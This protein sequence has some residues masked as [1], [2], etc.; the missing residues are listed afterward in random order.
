M[1][2][3]QK[4]KRGP[5]ERSFS[6]DHGDGR[7]AAPY[8][9]QNQ[10]IVQ[11]NQ[12]HYDHP[13]G[14]GRGGRGGYGGRGGAANNT[15]VPTSP[16]TV[17][18]SPTTEVATST[19]PPPSRTEPPKKPPPSPSV[20]KK[21]TAPAALP[22][23][24]PDPK[25]ITYHF[26]HL[27]DEVVSTWKT[28]G[29]QS[30]I[31]AAVKLQEDA[32]DTDPI[33]PVFQELIKSAIWRRLTPVEAGDAIKEIIAVAPK[34][35]ELDLPECFLDILCVINPD[36]SYPVRKANQPAPADSELD[37]RHFVFRQLLPATAISPQLMREILDPAI[38][39]GANMVRP[40]FTSKAIRYNTDLNYR[41]PSFNLLRED[42]EGF[43][44]LMTEYFTAASKS[45]LGLLKEQTDD[46]WEKI[47]ALVGAFDM[48]I[49]RV[50]DVTLTVFGSVLIRHSRFFVKLLRAS[51]WWPMKSLVDGFDFE[52][53]LSGLP[54]WA[55]PSSAVGYY[56]DEEKEELA[57]LRTSRDVAF[58]DRVRE[59]GI[60][61]YFALGGRRVKRQDSL[62]NGDG[63]EATTSLSDPDNSDLAWI[64]ATGTVRPNGSRLAAQVLGFNFQFYYGQAREKND[65]IPD[66]LV[67]L[68]AL[69]IKIGFISFL[70]FYPYVYP[71]DE[72]MD[73]VREKLQKEKELRDKGRRPNAGENALMRAGALPDDAPSTAPPPRIREPDT[74]GTA[75]KA[76]SSAAEKSVNDGKPATEEA[77]ALPEPGDQK[78]AL[79]KHLLALGA[80]PESVFILSKFP[81][82]V[83]LVPELPSYI[84][85]IVDY[86][87]SKIAQAS[88]Q[89]PDPRSVVGAKP[90]IAEQLTKELK[91]VDEA[92][93][94][95]LR[96]Q[97][98]DAKWHMNGA[99]YKFYWED[100]A[101]Q[102][103]QCQTVD[104]FFS[105]CGT[106]ANIL[107]FKIGHDPELYVKF[108]R[109][110]KYS[111]ATDRSDANVARWKD[112]CK[113]LLLPASTLLD[114]SPGMFTRPM[115]TLHSANR[116]NR[117]CI[118]TV[119][120]SQGLSYRRQVQ[121]V[122]RTVHRPN[123]EDGRHQDRLRPGERNDKRRAQENQQRQH[124]ATGPRARQMHV[125]STWHRV[126][127]D[128]ESD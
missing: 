94:K 39:Q 16:A 23:Y 8:N 4:R 102:I 126:C 116:N 82:L 106:F 100:W 122:R 31:D 46:M 101:D 14:R 123:L 50:V 5:G 105:F 90:V 69:L 27:T 57:R 17:T 124:E 80:L 95:Q 21:P 15:S 67:A 63:D 73:A 84:S 78:I 128:S 115:K 37:A 119:Q 22:P 110:G 98:L 96:W 93:R 99:D 7:R 58:W 70:D 13:R 28:G 72:N 121:H 11:R 114:E 85:R 55:E 34:S 1:A 59:D 74:R 30:I 56:T 111:L 108:I 107:G 40:H 125:D 20:V 9:P 86:S 120:P 6:G 79:L 127:G 112:L 64:E 41:A 48:D 81:W 10:S 97:G 83:D 103:P 32:E 61:A 18:P 36:L 53:G 113:R 3:G 91:V 65:T 66:N 35:K 44:K 54:K 87:V 47:K 33:S 2:P 109:I 38:L 60:S 77:E 49:S 89:I 75:T 76:D 12:Q 24:V 42:S 117:N 52:D 88:Y 71:A 118:R 29:R 19:M 25:L 51:S 45:N 43:S 26:E 104:D 92:S 68:A 62:K